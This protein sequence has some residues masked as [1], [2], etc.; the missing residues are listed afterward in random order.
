MPR[1]TRFVAPT[2]RFERELLRQGFE[3]IAGVDEVGRGSLA[4]PVVAASVILPIRS[5]SRMRRLAGLDDSKVLTGAQREMLYTSIAEIA[6]AIGIGWA[7][8]HVVD[9]DGIAAANRRALLRAVSN[10]PRLP[11]ALLLDHFALPQCPL[12]QL[13]LTHGDS[14]SLSIAAASV[15]AKVI[16]DRWMTRCDRIFPGYGFSG[17]KGYGTPGHRDALRRLGPCKLH[18]R[19]FQPMA[20]GLL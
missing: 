14:L 15:V 10:C 17:H 9:R 18:R 7:S 3:R 20:G 5:R 13:P 4:G 19:S 11:D 8:H 12:P 1:Y 16:R 2:L 6:L